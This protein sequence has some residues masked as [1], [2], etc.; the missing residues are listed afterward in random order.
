MIDMPEN[1]TKRNETKPNQTKSNQTKP[2]QTKRNQTKPN[3]TSDNISSIERDVNSCTEKA[4]I[5]IEQLMTMRKFDFFLNKI[6]W[7]IFY[8]VSFLCLMT[9]QP[10]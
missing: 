7:K 9:Y 5:A 1:E 10:L 4:L 6:K 2:N 3:Q 8:S